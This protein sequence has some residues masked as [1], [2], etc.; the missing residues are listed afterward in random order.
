MNQRAFVGEWIW[1]ILGEKQRPVEI[2]EFCI[3]CEQH[4]RSH[5]Q[6]CAY[7]A[8]D[9][10]PEP[11]FTSAVPQTKRGCQA[12]GFVQLDVDRVVLAKQRLK[13]VGRVDALICAYRHRVGNVTKDLVFACRE[14]LFD[15]SDPIPGSGEEMFPD[16]RFGPALI[17][18]KNDTAVWCSLCDS[19]NS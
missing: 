4:C 8:P 5:S 1:T 6:R 15:E 18:I 9:H 2:D 16:V 12:A 13:H 14:W 11:K 17:R 7:H 10:D 19:A 3:L